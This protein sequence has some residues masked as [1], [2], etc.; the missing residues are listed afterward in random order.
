MFFVGHFFF[1]IIIFCVGA[2]AAA[3]FVKGAISEG[4]PACLSSAFGDCGPWR[5][6]RGREL[7][8]LLFSW[9]RPP[10]SHI[11]AAFFTGAAPAGNVFYI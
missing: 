6:P 11:P 7:P 8:H 1:F 9:D 4:V 3:L 10:I 5:F 2:V